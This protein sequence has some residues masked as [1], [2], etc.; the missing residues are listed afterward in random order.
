MKVIVEMIYKDPDRNHNVSVE[1]KNGLTATR[2]LN[3]IE[4]AVEKKMKRDLDWNRWNVVS[5]EE[6][7]NEEPTSEVPSE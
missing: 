1:V 5:V 3:A 2:L 4:K 7:S 6:P